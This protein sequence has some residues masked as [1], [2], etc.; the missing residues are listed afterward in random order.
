MLPRVELSTV[1]T[2]VAA[3]PSFASL[4]LNVPSLDESF[5]QHEPTSG[6]AE[7]LNDELWASLSLPSRPVDPVAEQLAINMA[8]A[9]EEKAYE[10]ATLGGYYDSSNVFVPV[11]PAEAGPAEAAAVGAG[12]GQA[13]SA[14][15]VQYVPAYRILVSK[16]KRDV[17]TYTEPQA[18]SFSGA[19][20]PP[21]CAPPPD[22]RGLR[23]L[24]EAWRL[25][26][27]S[28]LTAV[29]IVPDWTRQQYLLKLVQKLRNAE[30]GAF[31]RPPPGGGRGSGIKNAVA[32][33]PHL[34]SSLRTA[35]E[36]GVSAADV[37]TAIA[38]E[39]WW[40]ERHPFYLL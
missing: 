38:S 26:E 8:L 18:Y 35:A 16:R 25:L 21:L 31:G 33:K 2:L 27:P 37:M 15:A 9:D 5:G 14:P 20:V 12:G 4:R 30:P 7:R 19:G 29:R 36:H 28:D 32:A 39:K 17:V 6:A 24:A 10:I 40:T 13:S 3:Q 34:V 11:A 23:H 1:P 22:S